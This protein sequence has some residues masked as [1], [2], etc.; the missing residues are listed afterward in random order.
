MFNN[1]KNLIQLISGNAL[2]KILEK[3]LKGQ[4]SSAEIAITLFEITN[5]C[6]LC[7]GSGNIENKKCPCCYGDPI[8]FWEN[9]IKR[10]KLILAI[11]PDILSV[12]LSSENSND[13][14]TT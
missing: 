12:V 3:K 11:I 1:L 4:L 13:D 2:Q 7:N 5:R 6:F 9:R 14:K 10:Y 8:Q